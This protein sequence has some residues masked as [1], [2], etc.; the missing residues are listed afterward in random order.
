MI[1]HRQS[2]ARGN[3]DFLCEGGHYRADKTFEVP[4]WTCIMEGAVVLPEKI[5]LYEPEHHQHT[6]PVFTHTPFTRRTVSALNANV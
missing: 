2:L 4:V 5:E 3:K 6:H 1:A